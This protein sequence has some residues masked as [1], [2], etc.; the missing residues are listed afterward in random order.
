MPEAVEDVVAAF[1]AEH[2]VEQTF[3]KRKRDRA[4][5]EA[6]ARRAP[7]SDDGDHERDERAE[8]FLE[9]W[10][11]R[12]LRTPSRRRRSKSKLRRRLKRQ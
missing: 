12:K 4:D 10:S 11:R 6:L 9:R 8:N 5:P 3:L 7:S 1:V 2:H